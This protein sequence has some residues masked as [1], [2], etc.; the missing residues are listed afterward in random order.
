[1]IISKVEGCRGLECQE[2]A[3]VRLEC[4]RPGKVDCGVSLVENEEVEK[5]D[6]DV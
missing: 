2:G 5:V 6:G 1:M 4:L 3:G